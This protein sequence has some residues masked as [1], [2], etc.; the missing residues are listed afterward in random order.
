M[1]ASRRFDVPR[2]HPTPHSEQNLFALRTRL[3]RRR[4]VRDL[5]LAI[6]GAPAT[7]TIA[8]PADPNAVLDEVAGSFSVRPVGL[9]HE[10]APP[11]GHIARSL[12]PHMPYWA[13]PWASGLALAEAILARRAQVRTRRVLELGCG[14]GITAAAVLDAGGRL[15]VADC[16]SETLLYCRYNCLRNARRAPYTLLAD[17]RTTPGR[18]A[19]LA[20]GPADLLLAADVLYERED[21]VPLLDLVPELLSP[22]G[23]FWLAEPGRQTSGRFLQEARVR[24]WSAE[25]LTQER[26][27]PG[28]AGRAA[29]RL[30]FYASVPRAQSAVATDP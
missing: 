5:H 29:V 3:E 1:T 27:W 20:A 11:T 23:A 9:I 28:D 14:L 19:L 15:T 26:T 13:T 4:A 2:R 12:E 7:Y 16:I 22:H 17:W 18:T 6:P 8:A 10:A 21:V 30:H 24:G 25:R